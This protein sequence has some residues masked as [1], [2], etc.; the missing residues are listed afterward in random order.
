M[1]SKKHNKVLNKTKKK[2]TH[3]YRKQTSACQRREE[4]GKG[5]YKHSENKRTIM[6]N[7]VCETSKN[8]DN[9]IELKESFIQLKK[10]TYLGQIYSVAQ[11][12]FNKKM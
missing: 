9:T 8:L 12:K 2:Q 7:H 10:K 5:Q 4:R 3:W 1:E 6:L 11:R